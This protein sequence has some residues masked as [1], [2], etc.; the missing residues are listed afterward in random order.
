MKRRIWGTFTALAILLA[1]I[2]ARAT[3]CT[4]SSA[5]DAGAGTLRDA[6]ANTGCDTI[7]FGITGAITLTSGELLVNRNVTITGPGAGALAVTRDSN[8]PAFRIFHIASGAVAISGVTIANGLSPATGWPLPG[9]G[10]GGIYT[11]SSATLTLDNT[12]VSGNGITLGLGSGGLSG[13]GGILNNGTLTIRNSLI[14]GN[15]ACGGP[16][17]CVYG[18]G[19]NNF[20]ML[21]ITGT[22][23]SANNSS[24]LGPGYGGAI[25]NFSTMTITSSVITGNDN[26]RGGGISNDGT[27]VLTNSTV[28]GNTAKFDGGGILNSATAT[29]IG[30]TISGNNVSEPG[31]I[32]DP[33]GGGGV[34]N[35]GNLQV[36]NS[37]FSNNTTNN[38]GGGILDTHSF[39]GGSVLTNTTFSGNS[40]LSANNIA[41]I[42]FQ[43]TDN[44]DNPIGGPGSVVLRNTIVASTAGQNCTTRGF[45]F[46][47]NFF[48]PITDGGYN[49]ENGNTCGFTAASKI[50]TDPLLG[51]LQ[52]NGGA[53][54]TQALLPVSPAIDAGS[55]TDLNGNAVTADQRGVARP[56]GVTC[57]IGAYEYIPPFP[58][59]GFYQPVSNPPALNQVKAGAAVPVQFSL[60]GNR[61]LNIFAVNS[62]GSV[63]IVCSTSAPVSTVTAT[64]TA[65][66][67]SLSYNPSTDTYTYT[68]KTDASWSGTCRQLS[69]NLTDGTTHVANFQF[70]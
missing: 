13:G 49:L 25:E 19:I 53:T 2:A 30:C 15:S 20:G 65:G 34:Y 38:V 12:T 66:G 3:T 61:G 5:A 36:T 26:G 70:K 24:N 69:V 37:T 57:D 6:I 35:G 10:G 48:E 67:S 54:Q 68:W 8:A 16:F 7:S 14:S 62:P 44:D 17:R 28:S 43:Q 60:S 29:L 42:F 39:G 1:P 58:F 23:L 33:D 11:D 47:G 22:T 52:N 9:D 55:C 45:L 63:Q 59:T 41:N 46:F 56:Q 31:D 64:V 32:G 50:N 40:A 18:N 51:P 27:M 21:T 4:V